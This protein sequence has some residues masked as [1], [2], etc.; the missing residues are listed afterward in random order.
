MQQPACANCSR[1][2]ETC[3]YPP[4]VDEGWSTPPPAAYSTLGPQLGYRGAD[5]SSAG[6]AAHASPP[7][8]PD[9]VPSPTDSKAAYCARTRQLL[10]GLLG[11]G[12]WFSPP[13]RALWTEGVAKAAPKYP[14]L[15]HCVQAVA[16][17]RHHNQHGLRWPSTNAYRHQLLASKIFRET[18][19]SVDGDN[20]MA[21]LAFATIM[22]IFQFGSQLSCDEQHFNVVETLQALRNTFHIEVAARPYFRQTQVWKLIQAR[23]SMPSSPDMKLRCVYRLLGNTSVLSFQLQHWARYVVDSWTSTDSWTQIRHALP[24]FCRSQ[25]FPRRQRL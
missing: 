18:T 11:S 5:S 2:G 25:R 19:P 14:Y 9:L 3:E 20:W 12:S 24:V 7:F 17:L 6:S 1:R 15:Q 22:L 8:L 4:P 21:V 13:E 23:T 10:D 16:H